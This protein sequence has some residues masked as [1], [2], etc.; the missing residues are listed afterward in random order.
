M[1]NAISQDSVPQLKP[2][3]GWIRRWGKR[4][5]SL[6]SCLGQW[7]TV[8]GLRRLGTTIGNSCFIASGKG[9]TGRK[10]LLVI[11]DNCF[12]GRANIGLHA[13]V[14]IGSCVCINDGAELLTASHDVASSTWETVAA[15]ITIGDHAWI[16][17]NSVILPGVTIGTGAVVGAGAVVSRDVSPYAIVVGNPAKPIRRQRARDLSYSP[18]DHVA[19]I[20][21]WR[22]N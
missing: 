1:S 17:K 7:R 4:V 13:P 8:A 18:V 19:L 3:S 20:R 2:V 9:I 14:T 10:S 22:N 6:P 12:I 21:A 15:P 11:G 16:A 5:Q